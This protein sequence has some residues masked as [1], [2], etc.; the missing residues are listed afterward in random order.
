M[1][2]DGIVL[3]HIARMFMLYWVYFYWK[4]SVSYNYETPLI[5]ISV[6][7]CFYCCTAEGLAALTH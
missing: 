3:V 2:L 7:A 1:P 5:W 6:G 4:L